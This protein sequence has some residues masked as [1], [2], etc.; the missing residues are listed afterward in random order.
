[1]QY[2]IRAVPRE[3]DMILR[4]RALEAGT[5]L[6]QI[7]LDVLMRGAEIEAQRVSRRNLSDLCGRMEPDSG[8]DDA[9]RDQ[10]RVDAA[11]WL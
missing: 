8:F 10:E 1:M 11:L 5:S 6:N 3:L 9:I 7:L 2:T 4:K